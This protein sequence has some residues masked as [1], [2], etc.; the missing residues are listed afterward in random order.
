MDLILTPFR[1]FFSFLAISVIIGLEI[2]DAL[3]V[4]SC[5][6][7]VEVSYVNNS[8]GYFFESDVFYSRSVV[9]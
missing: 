5:Q 3:L 6:I 7:S 8:L 9:P 1:P 2:T 4:L